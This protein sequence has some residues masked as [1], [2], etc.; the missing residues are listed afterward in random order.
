M[1][2]N[3][4]YGENLV[5]SRLQPLTGYNTYADNEFRLSNKSISSWSFDGD[6]PV[7]MNYVL[8]WNKNTATFNIKPGQNM[9]FTEDEEN[10][11]VRQILEVYTDPDELFTNSIVSNT[12]APSQIVI[13]SATGSGTQITYVADNNLQAGNTVTITG[14]SPSGYNLSN[15]EVVSAT[16][17]QF[18]VA[19]S[20]TTPST[21]GGSLAVIKAFNSDVY[22][23]YLDDQSIE[24]VKTITVQFDND[25][26]PRDQ[27]YLVTEDWENRVEGSSGW[28]I[29]SEGNS[30][31][32]NVAVRGQISAQSG[33]FDGFLT[34]NNGTMKIG[35]GVSSTSNYSVS[36]FE[37]LNEQVT[38][39]IG[40]HTLS[41]SD[42]VTISNVDSLSAVFA[43]FP[44][45]ANITN[46]VGNG[47]QVTYT[48]N[49]AFTTGSTVAII[50]TTPTS[51]EKESAAILSA[52]S[53]GFTIASTVI[54][55]YTS[56]GVAI[57]N[58]IPVAGT[59]VNGTYTLSAVGST[60]ITYDLQAPDFP[61]TAVSYGSVISGVG[62]D[63]IYINEDN[64]WYSDGAISIGQAD[65]S[66][67]YDGT[68]VT[69]GADVVINASLTAD[70]LTV[71]T[72]PDFMVISDNANGLGDAGLYINSNNHWYSDGHFK[73]GNSTN[74]VEWEGSALTVKGTL[75]DLELSRGG[76][77]IATNFAVGIDAL[78]NNTTGNNNIA[79][80][81]EALFSNTIGSYN[82]ASGYRALYSN[83][84]GDN[85]VAFGTEAL[86][87]N[88]TGFLNV[89]I[90]YQSLLYNTTGTSNIALGAGT[91]KQNTIGG[92]NVAVGTYAMQNNTTGYRNIAIGGDAL[93]QNQTGFYNIAIGDQ[94]LF[95]NKNVYNI[96]IGSGSLYDNTGGSSNIA[97]GY[98]ALSSNTTGLQNIAI[99]NES[100]KRNTT[101]IQNVAIG[102]EALY[103][104]TTGEANIA[105]GQSSLNLN[106][107]GIRNI[108]IGYTSL[109]A[110]TI[111]YMNTA[112]GV[113]SL[114]NNTEGFFNTAIGTD[115]LTQ[116]TVGQNNVAIG[117]KSLTTNTTSSG[118][119]AIGSFSLQSNKVSNQV[120]I[121]ES[122]LVSNTTG[123]YNVA[124]GTY[125]LSGNTTGSYNLAIGF[126]ALASNITG[127]NNTAIGYQALKNNKNS[128]NFAIGYQALLSNTD[129][130]QNVAL[131][132]AALYDNTTG[133]NNIAIG[134]ST[135]ASNTT[136]VDNVAIGIGGMASN[137]EGSE[138]I[139]VGMY[140][141]LSNT[142]GTGNVAV[143]QYAL[144]NNEHE[145]YNVAIGGGALSNLQG[146]G[147]FANGNIGIGTGAGSSMVDGSQNI[148]IGG[149]G[150]GYGFVNGNYNIFIGNADVTAYDGLSSYIV[151]SDGFGN[152]ALEVDPAQNT[153]FQGQVRANTY[154]ISAIELNRT[155]G[156]GSASMV[157]F[158]RS[159]GANAGGINA[160]TGASPSFYSPSDY[161]LKE[162]IQDYVGAIDL[163]KQLKPRTYN[164]INDENTTNV[165]GFIA[166]EYADVFPQFVIGEKD[167]VDGDG[168]PEYQSIETT[169]VI[170]YLIAALKESIEKIESLEARL[171]QIENV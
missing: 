128:N 24:Q 168:N 23:K 61:E 156:T 159:G 88:T 69:I 166:H 139:S 66:I 47:T 48:A 56:G 72:S 52:T 100:L 68:N 93:S 91:L 8:L 49:N 110:N 129:G 95:S 152:I 14:M 97:V 19:G 71:G 39:T 3:S 144:A 130:I 74:Y 33:N 81:Q 44:E 9:I 92:K 43:L 114:R 29:T 36:S 137:T 104:N 20:E 138:N 94:A 54:D 62:S 140:A 27:I 155:D 64:Y 59:D 111:G 85:N 25:G 45:P 82:V 135:L 165:L 164:F 41:I 115:A 161:R 58:S 63:G 112:I 103:A 106:T 2:I 136:G 171:A 46:A 134:Y 108:A 118:N 150:C 21:V 132:Q 160:S 158:K 146:I 147:A 142:T 124:I 170:P 133:Q 163:I 51:F 4:S 15:V 141:L 76:G 143:G 105:I 113:A 107:T 98:N 10:P 73:V 80:G 167:A 12:T 99:G 157:E 67:V 154:S 42:E 120:A 162:N 122:S 55:T 70:S 87:S 26:Y 1:T 149:F 127:N 31:F 131:G 53:T 50:G 6:I 153:S 151:L 116:N 169:S 123:Q 35:S 28:I 40:T 38:L 119:I 89:A 13:D 109:Y 60:T 34:V 32:N 30:I 86:S 17:T 79:L 22:I 125:S 78:N 83:I 148:F 57:I 11:Y 117:Y 102:G 145:S 5:N 18:V 16:S 75:N 77:N 65:N 37:I 7:A 101:G 84:D 96:A 121:G 90:G 126:T